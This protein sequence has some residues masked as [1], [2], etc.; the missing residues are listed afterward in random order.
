ME[1]N[2]L[3][4]F[5]S[6]AVRTRAVCPVLMLK[7]SDNARVT[8]AGEA[9]R[10]NVNGAMANEAI[11]TSY[12]HQDVSREPSDAAVSSTISRKREQLNVRGCGVLHRKTTVTF[13][14][15]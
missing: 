10:R 2:S 3:G 15:H 5:R 11:G 9:S 12:P 13:L 8:A 4:S 6:G 1:S 14:T 7:V